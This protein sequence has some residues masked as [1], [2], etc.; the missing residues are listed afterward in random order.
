VADPVRAR[1]SPG[2]LGLGKIRFEVAEA[3]W[4]TQFV[5]DNLPKS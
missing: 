3:E 2:E 1:K 5:A 4:L